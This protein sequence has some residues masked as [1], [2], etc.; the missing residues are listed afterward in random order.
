MIKVSDYVSAFLVARG[1]E[2][3][4]LVS[5]GGIMHLLESVGRQEGLRYWCNYHEQACAAAAEAWA[6]LHRRPCA[7]LVTVGPGG[8]NALSGAAG[9]WVDSVPMLVFTG[10]VRRDLMADYGLQ[11]QKG[12]QEGDLVGLAGHLTK[13]AVT[14]REPDRIRYELE[15]A[16]Y[17]ATS[18][19]PGP[20]LIDLPLDVQGALVDEDALA[21]FAPAPEAAP[22]L[23]EAVRTAAAW[24]RASRRPVL[25][26]GNGVGWAR[27]GDALLDL[28]AATRIP[29]ITT[30]TAKDLLWEDHPQ[31]LGCFGPLGQRRANFTLQNA[32]LLLSVGSG[33]CVAKSGFNVAGFSPG[34]R[35]I[36]VDID[37]G[38]LHHQPIAA[39]LAVQA[40]AGDFLR[41]LG[42]ALDAYEPPRPWLEACAQWKARYPTLE[43]EHLA[44]SDHV[45][46]YRLLDR[47]SD[48]MDGKDTVVTGNG[49]DVVSYIQSFRITRG[50]RALQNGNWGAMGWDLPLAV[51][52]AVARPGHRVVLVTGDGSFQWNIQELLTLGSHRLPVCIFVLNNQ[53]YSSIRATQNTY[54]GG[55][56]VGAE[57][58]S[59]VA[60]PDFRLLAGA[61]GLAYDRI[62]PAA[63][64]DAELER[65]LA[66]PMPRLC[67]VPVAP[68]QPI[69]PKA[70]SARRADGTMESRPLEDMFPFLPREEIQ[71]NMIGLRGGA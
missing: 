68:D 13:Y 1:I 52:A 11:R 47:L 54:F 18:G 30:H 56:F 7:V 27:A 50:Q 51:G 23:E 35:K 66:G 44:P 41:A 70:S 2:D 48:H 28:L 40:D 55:H 45:N 64:L 61:Y 29:A 63:D 42:R 25:M 32:D 24:I 3:I 10:Q 37:P 6:K 60:N 16:W 65:V 33:L 71:A 4:F 17:L 58:G 67:E 8:L 62:D 69:S 5:G 46:T 53:G 9:A 15:K 26:A 34:S 14:V 57:A 43:A 22:A 20:V 31:N 38:Q 19:R 21:P 36:L 12:P 39:D 59:G 49:M